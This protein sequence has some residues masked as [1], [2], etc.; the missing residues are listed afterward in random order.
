M[1]TTQ[2][3]IR[4]PADMTNGPWVVTIPGV[5]RGKQRARIV[6][7]GAYATA[8]TPRETMNAEAWVKHCVIEQ[9]G[10]LC[11]EGPLSLTAT[12]YVQVAPSWPTRKRELAL[13][14]T[15]YPTGK[16]DLDNC[17]KLIS[18]ALNGVMWRD[19]SQIVRLAVRKAY[20]SKPSTIIEVA[21]M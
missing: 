2:P 8:Y 5:M 10:L 9:V 13:A 14:G 15:L 3:F 12:I 18:D 4:V 21:A 1:I 17:I 7:R 19:D 11:L 20:A 6:R 16:P